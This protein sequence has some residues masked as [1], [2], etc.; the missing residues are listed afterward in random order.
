MR[1]ILLFI[2][3]L[4]SANAFALNIVFVTPSFPGN[5]FWDRVSA[6]ALACANNLNINLSIVYGKNNRIQQ[7]ETVKKITLSQTKPDYV[8]FSPYGGTAIGA[9]TLLNDAKIPFVTLERTLSKNEIEQIGLP[10]TKYVNWLGGIFHDNKSAGKLLADELF[11]QFQLAN[12]AFN[13]KINIVGLAGSHSEESKNRVLG[14]KESAVNTNLTNKLYVK[15][16]NWEREEGKRIIFELAEQIEELNIIWSASDEMALGAIDIINSGYKKVGK[17]TVVGGIDW[18]R[19]GIK[20]ISRGELNASVGGHF[21]MA[22]WSII[23]IYD[24][25]NGK[26]SFSKNMNEEVYNL[27]LITA[28][29]VDEYLPL[30]KVVDWQQLN[31]KGFTLTHNENL[32]K[33]DFNVKRIMAELSN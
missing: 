33:Y 7:Y 21:M 27:T 5:P 28:N 17:N 32:K 1:K 3:L 19:E 9:F 30:A 2:F 14:L 23:K 24:H 18:T 13:K 11:S 10:Q 8:I 20:S 26:N 12:K 29:N 6:V 16:A 25:H 15:N 4:F 31:F 22:A